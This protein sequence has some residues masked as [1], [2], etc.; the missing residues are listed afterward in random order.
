MGVESWKACW[1]RILTHHFVGNGFL[2]TYFLCLLLYSEISLLVAESFGVLRLSVN[3]ST[4]V[5][6]TQLDPTA[7]YIGLDYDYRY[8]I[9]ETLHIQNP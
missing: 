9:N 6:L 8:N 4:P 2:T 5:A 7:F 3:G 1:A